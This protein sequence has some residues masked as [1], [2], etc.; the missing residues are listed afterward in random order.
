MIL[1]TTVLQVLMIDPKRSGQFRVVRRYQPPLFSSPNFS[2][3]TSSN[4][5][6]TGWKPNQASRAALKDCNPSWVLSPDATS[7]IPRPNY[8]WRLLHNHLDGPTCPQSSGELDSRETFD[9][10]FL[11]SLQRESRL[12]EIEPLIHRHLQTVSGLL[13]VSC[14]VAAKRIGFAMQSSTVYPA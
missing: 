6:A 13:A 14:T 7:A 12:D 2:K 1:D 5:R 8:F 9:F 11:L 4:L 10:S 3:L